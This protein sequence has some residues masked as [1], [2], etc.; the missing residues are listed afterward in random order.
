MGKKGGVGK[1]RF[2]WNLLNIKLGTSHSERR[3]VHKQDN[4][5]LHTLKFKSGKIQ[6]FQDVDVSENNGTPKSSILIG[7]S[8]INHPFG[9]P[10]FFGNTHV[11]FAVLADVCLF[12]R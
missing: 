10:L 9:E 4:W 12:A 11:N 7:F 2:Q 8:I 1:T 6:R 3:L 5:A